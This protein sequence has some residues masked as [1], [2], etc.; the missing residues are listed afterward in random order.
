MRNVQRRFQRNHTRLERMHD[1]AEVRDDAATE[2]GSEHQSAGQH[3]R[4]AD[5]V[6]RDQSIHSISSK[7]V[8][9][10]VARGLLQ[11][12]TLSV[13]G[14][15]SPELTASSLIRAIKPARQKTSP[16]LLRSTSR[17][18]PSRGSNPRPPS[19][20][21]PAARRRCA[22]FAAATVALPSAPSSTTRSS[23]CAQRALETSRR[24]RGTHVDRQIEQLDRDRDRATRRS[25]RSSRNRESRSRS[26]RS[27]VRL[28]MSSVG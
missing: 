21:P 11:S 20:A 7:V 9:H 6:E 10:A 3:C 16:R 23:A 27:R 5:K 28:R 19:A 18:P 26:H 13:R 15:G 8:G 24:M 2:Q 1:S 14:A 12:L 4:I 17:L 25:G 22:R